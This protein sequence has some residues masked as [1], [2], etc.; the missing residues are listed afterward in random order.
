MRLEESDAQRILAAVAPLTMVP[1]AGVRFTMD[2]AIAAAVDGPDGVLVECGVWKGGCSIAML[3]AQYA[4]IGMVLKPVHLLDSFEGLPPVEPI[5]GPAAAAW[6]AD[7]NSPRYFDNCR[8]SKSDVMQSIDAFGFD[9][10]AYRMWPGWFADTLPKFLSCGDQIALL[11]IDC[12]WYASVR[13]CLD[14]LMPRVS[15]GA[16]VIVDDYYAWSG[17]ARAVH[18]YFSANNTAYRLRSLPGD[19]G[20]YFVKDAG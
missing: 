20:A 6:Q 3:L 14:L 18:D 10:G 17:C 7:K 16:T 8:A 9:G 13:L 11:R 1:D 4:A 15:A 2:A 12:D 19:A 5:D